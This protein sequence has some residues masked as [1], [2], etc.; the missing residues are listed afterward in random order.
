MSGKNERITRRTDEDSVAFARRAILF[1]FPG[2]DQDWAT[3]VADKRDFMV[4]KIM[5]EGNIT[6]VSRVE[7]YTLLDEARRRMNNRG[8]T[9]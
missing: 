2:N 5:N 3:L 7:V 1:T 8:A 6:S 4:S 9:T